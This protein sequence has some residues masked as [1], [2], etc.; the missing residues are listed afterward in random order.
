MFI[1]PDALRKVLKFNST[2][3]A[4]SVELSRIGRRLT[5]AAATAPANFGYHQQVVREAATIWP[6]HVTLTFNL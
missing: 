4:S 1:A 5:S 3:L 2:Q 6:T